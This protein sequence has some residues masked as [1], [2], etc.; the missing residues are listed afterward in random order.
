MVSRKEAGSSDFYHL[1]KCETS[2]YHI[3]RVP[4]VTDLQPIECETVQEFRS[5]E[6]DQDKAD[7]LQAEEAVYEIQDRTHH[8]HR[9]PDRLRLRRSQRQRSQ[10]KV[11]FPSELQAVPHQRS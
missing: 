7:P 6:T 3:T 11:L 1:R 5:I 2:Q 9:R 10:G 4:R 8:R